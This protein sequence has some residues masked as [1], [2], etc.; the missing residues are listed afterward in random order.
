MQGGLGERLICWS[1]E[2]RVHLHKG[3]TWH[4]GGVG[5]GCKILND[6]VMPV[7]ERQ[8]GEGKA[9]CVCLTHEVTTPPFFL[10][11]CLEGQKLPFWNVA[12]LGIPKSP[13]GDEILCRSKKWSNVVQDTPQAQGNITGRKTLPRHPST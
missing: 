9:Q 1:V 2:R 11:E 4:N 3:A 12:H 5:G 7:L 10:F 13:A 8:A 6:A